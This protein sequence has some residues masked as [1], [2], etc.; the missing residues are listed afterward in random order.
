MRAI[1]PFSVVTFSGLCGV[2]LADTRNDVLE[3]LTYCNTFPDGRTWLDCYY[4]AAQPERAEL[5]LP[6]AP[7]APTFESLFRRPAPSGSVGLTTPTG[8]G[9]DSGGGFLGLLSADKVP[10]EQFGL[11]NARPG[12]GPN[13]DRIVDKLASY[14]FANGKFTVTL[15]N[16][17]VW[18]QT[19]GSQVNWRRTPADYTATITHGA[20]RTFNLRIQAGPNADDTLYK[21]ERIH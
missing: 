6:P 16:G 10:P 14:T 20:L 15:A 11:T 9:A 12:P 17:Q 13:V 8:A 2:A 4:A 5:G 1:I 3:R 7:Q 19:G 21:V 18:R